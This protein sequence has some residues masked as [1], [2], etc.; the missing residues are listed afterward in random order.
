MKAALR[1]VFAIL[2]LLPLILFIKQ[3]LYILLS[4]HKWHALERQGTI[5]LELGSGP[6]KGTNG[7]TTIDLIGADICYDLRKGIPLPNDCVEKI[8]TS[9]MFEHIPYRQLR[10]FINECYRVLI[11]NGEL[12]VCVPNA[13][14][15]ISAYMEGEWFLHSKEDYYEPALVETGS[16]LDQV[17]YI[18]YMNGHHNYMFDEQNLINTLKLAPFS[19]VKLRSFNQSIDMIERDFESIYAIAV[20]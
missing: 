20:K 1:M 4:K 14:L 10:D 8:Y 19:M 16:L 9:H 2:G 3:K 7:W 6:K 11:K 17:N 18:A 13:R 15:Y 5:W 12:Y